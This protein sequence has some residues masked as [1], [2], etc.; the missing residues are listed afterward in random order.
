[1]KL[2]FKIRISKPV[3]FNSDNFKKD[4]KFHGWVSSYTEKNI[5]EKEMLEWVENTTN[6]VFLFFLL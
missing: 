2:F 5:P 1:M 6:S 4:S 3:L